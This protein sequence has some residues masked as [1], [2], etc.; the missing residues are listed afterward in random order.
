[1]GHSARRALTPEFPPRP[2]TLTRPSGRD[3]SRSDFTALDFSVTKFAPAL[4]STSEFA[5]TSGAHRVGKSFALPRTSKQAGGKDDGRGANNRRATELT[6]RR[7][8]HPTGERKPHL[9]PCAEPPDRCCG[10][11]G[12]RPWIYHGLSPKMAMGAAARFYGNLLDSVLGAMGDVF[13]RLLIC[14]PVL[15]V[16][17]A[18]G[19]AQ[20]PAPAWRI[21][22]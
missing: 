4:T 18:G 21:R 12:Y 11:G 1:M 15:L 14:L 19:A 17:P 13:R 16:E 5:A 9:P 3:V 8:G 6:Y 7:R 22:E 20:P 10:P 2:R